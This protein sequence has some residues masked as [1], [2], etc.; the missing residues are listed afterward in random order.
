MSETHYFPYMLD[1]QSETH[2]AI[3]QPG[4]EGQITVKHGFELISELT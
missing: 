2:S 3:P 1:L 4:L